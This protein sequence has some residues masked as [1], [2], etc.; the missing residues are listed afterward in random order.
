MKIRH[1]MGKI[2][3]RKIYFHIIG[4]AFVGFW[5]VMI[6]LL[7]RKVHFQGTASE[8]DFEKVAFT[9]DSPQR[10]WKEIYLKNSKVGYATDLIKPFEGGYFIQEE[11]FLKLNLMGLDSGVYTLTQSRVDDQFLLKSFNFFVCF[12]PHFMHLSFYPVSKKPSTVLL[13]RICGTRGGVG[14]DFFPDVHTQ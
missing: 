13:R 4:V 9:I 7:V 14:A 10:E 3:K 5:L 2:S 11:I 8:A 1:L 6:G 12:Q